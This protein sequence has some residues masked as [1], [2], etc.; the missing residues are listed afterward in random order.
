[1]K[2]FTWSYSSLSAFET[3][4][5]RFYE[6]RIAKRVVEPQ[7]APLLLGNAAH[8]CLELRVDRG[9]PLPPTIQVT[10]TDGTTLQQSTQGWEAIVKAVLRR[11]D[12]ETETVVE[13]QIALDD[14]FIETDW[15]GSDTWVRGVIDLGLIR[16]RKALLLDW[17]TGKRK[18][19]IDQ[20]ELF[21]ALAMHAYPK[22]DVVHTGFVWLKSAKIDKEEYT[23]ADIPKIWDRF[24]PRVK[25]MKQAYAENVW[26]ERP[27]G[28]CKRHCPV[29][30][31]IHNGEFSNVRTG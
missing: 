6:T 19:D 7:G 10:A 22:L 25:R 24:L 1:M 5:R 17:K 31:C 23:R 4:P 16:P 2:P 28:L 20:L 26:P 15:F 12:A 13:R 8:K 3:C 14:R 9:T 30:N 18:L 27:S 21:S 11:V 29:H